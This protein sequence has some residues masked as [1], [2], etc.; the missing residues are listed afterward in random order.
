MTYAETEVATS[1]T[2]DFVN[3]SRKLFSPGGRSSGNASVNVP[4]IRR[5]YISHAHV[6][7]APAGPLRD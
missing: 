1:P 7:A 6:Y 3:T 2:L 5:L 4:R